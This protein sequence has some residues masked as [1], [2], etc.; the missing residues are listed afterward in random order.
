M[1]DA[2]TSAGSAALAAWLE[3]APQRLLL[4]FEGLLRVL[5][6]PFGMPEQLLAS[7]HKVRDDA[8]ELLR[9]AS[10]IRGEY[11]AERAPFQEHVAVRALVYDFLVHHAR[12][13]RGWADLA[14]IAVEAW[15]ELT[16]EERTRRALAI[17]A[18]GD[19]NEAGAEVAVEVTSPRSSSATTDAS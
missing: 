6:A 13:V 3:T 10:A 11:L 1:M 18:T 5:L 19:A 12:M 15:P 7:L 17:F 14:I 8:D 16:A 9:L 4:E 2:I